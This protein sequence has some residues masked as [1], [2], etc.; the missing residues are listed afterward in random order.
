MQHT[1]S[2]LFVFIARG[3][4]TEHFKLSVNISVLCLLFLNC[5]SSAIK[6]ILSQ[7]KNCSHNIRHH[8]TSVYT[9]CIPC[10]YPVYTLYCI[11]YALYISCKQSYEGSPLLLL[12]ISSPGFTSSQ[13]DTVR[14][15][16]RQAATKQRNIC[17]KS[18]LWLALFNQDGLR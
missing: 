13:Q 17:K 3:G 12:T 15:R 10:I 7:M 16:H 1:E 14:Y 6:N 11:V 9:L 4:K 8:F 2:I 18:E 5:Q